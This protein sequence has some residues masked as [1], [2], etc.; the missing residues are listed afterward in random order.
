MELVDKN[1]YDDWLGWKITFGQKSLT[2]ENIFDKVVETL[3]IDYVD[4]YSLEEWLDNLD[5][6]PILAGEKAIKIGT[7]VIMAEMP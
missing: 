6:A 5:L 7:L 4:I 3:G 1:L 2:K